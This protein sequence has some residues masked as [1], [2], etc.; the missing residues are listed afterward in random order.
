MTAAGGGAEDR[1]EIRDTALEWDLGNLQKCRKHGMTPELIREVFTS[2]PTVFDDPEHSNGE[3]RLRAV[4]RTR[5]GRFALVV[6]TLRDGG[7]RRLVRPIS[8]RY[9]HRKEIDSYE[10]AAALARQR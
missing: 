2:E 1:A 9:M 7:G 3:V 6:F 5:E 4:G 10:R 8:A